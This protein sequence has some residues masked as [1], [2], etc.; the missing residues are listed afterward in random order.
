M[1]HALLLV[2]NAPPIDTD[3]EEDESSGDDFSGRGE[4]LNVSVDDNKKIKD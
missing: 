2:P 1:L 3:V 4:Y